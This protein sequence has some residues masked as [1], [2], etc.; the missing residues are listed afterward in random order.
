MPFSQDPKITPLSIARFIK[1]YDVM[2][3]TEENAQAYRIYLDANENQHH[4]NGKTKDEW[5]THELV[6][7]LKGDNRCE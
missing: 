5:Y 2:C 3:T 4:Y 1:A 7:Y 6:T